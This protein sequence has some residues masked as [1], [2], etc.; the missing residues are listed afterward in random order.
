MVMSKAKVLVAGPAEFWR[1]VM[2]S[3]TDAQNK[4]AW[5]AKTVI[6]VSSWCWKAVTLLALS[7]VHI[8]V[9]AI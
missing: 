2:L 5:K 1:D 4:S 6:H 9:P 3:D 7:S 8:S